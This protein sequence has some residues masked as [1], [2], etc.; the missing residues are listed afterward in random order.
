M[1][2]HHAL[3]FEHW[4]ALLDHAGQ[5]ILIK[6]PQ[7]YIICNFHAELYCSK[8]L[9]HF[10]CHMIGCGS[11]VALSV[12]TKIIIMRDPKLIFLFHRDFRSTI[13]LVKLL[14]SLIHTLNKLQLH[15][16]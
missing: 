13:T 6:R 3:K 14:S 8:I 16:A 15:S 7:V 12:N 1:G 2:L 10:V 9:Q 4:V 5:C 11:K